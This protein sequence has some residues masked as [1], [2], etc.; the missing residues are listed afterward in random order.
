MGNV[1]YVCIFDYE[2]RKGKKRDFPLSA[3]QVILSKARLLKEAG[4][5][6]EI[7]SMSSVTGYGFDRGGCFELEKKIVLRLFSS[8][9]HSNFL[10]RVID[11][12]WIRLQL[13]LF[14]LGRLKKCDAII[15]YHSLAYMKII[16]FMKKLKKNSLILEVQEIYADVINNKKNR[17]NEIQ[18]IKNADAYIFP[19]EILNRIL[20]QD[21]KPS[22]IAP[23][24]YNV[25]YIG[26]NRANRQMG[27]TIHCVYAGTL[28]LRKGCLEAIRAGAFLTLQYHIHIIGFGTD[29]EIEAVKTEI[30]CLDSSNKAIVTYD[31]C[32]TGE[33]YIS[34]L[35]KCDIGLSLQNPEASFNMTSFPSKILSYLSNGLRVVSIRIPAIEQSSVGDLLYFY[36]IQTPEAIANRIKSIEMNYP[37]DS[38]KRIKSLR[39]QLKVDL[40]RLVRN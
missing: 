19:T 27:D 18:Y 20:N 7:V 5:D 14:L 39:E 26:E 34:F 33:D 21:I 30:E 1:Y 9:G 31:G 40:E 35:Q 36:D 3:Q 8:I 6:V 32:Y 16:S 38:R 15:V 23:G 28:D 37:Y 13:V 2:E 24:S 22:V 12:Y 29:K 10:F 25:E 4:L 17:E 11:H